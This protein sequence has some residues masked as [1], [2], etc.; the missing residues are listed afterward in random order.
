VKD[1]PQDSLDDFDINLYCL[2]PAQQVAYGTTKPTAT[3]TGDMVAQGNGIVTASNP[4]DA[5]Y[6]IV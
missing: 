2:A 5:T 4:A 1:V 3:M 6:F